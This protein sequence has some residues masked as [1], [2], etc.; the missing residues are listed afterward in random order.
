MAV[1]IIVK[2]KGESQNYSQKFLLYDN[3]IVLNES[4]HILQQC[5]NEA[6]GNYKGEIDSIVVK[7]H[8]EIT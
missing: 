2:I 4:C 5:V 1:E 6:K 3:E 7:A 8:M